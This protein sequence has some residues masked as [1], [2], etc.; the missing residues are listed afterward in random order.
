MVHIALVT[1][2]FF[3]TEHHRALAARTFESIQTSHDLEIISIINQVRAPSD[4]LWLRERC[5]VVERNDVNILAR[6]WNKGIRLGLER[7]ASHVIVSNLD[8]R[9]HPWCIDNLVEAAQRNPDTLV[10]SPF[11]WNDPYTFSRAKL[12][13]RCSRG[14]HWSCFMVDQRLF[15]AV[16]EFDEKFRPAY[17][18]DAD[19]VRRMSL[20]Q[21]SGLTCR[22]ATVLN[23]GRGTIKGMLSCEQSQLEQ[24]AQILT[25]LRADIS[26]NDERYAR[27]WGGAPGSERFAAPFDGA[28]D[29]DA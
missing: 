5:A 11:L 26:R 21:F 18:E 12:E 19:M 25:A 27:K 24:C 13:P 7:G 23:D 3:V 29:P 20:K 6:A 28:A 17:L 1:V 8:I 16:G 10:F 9:F 14:L 2:P 15:S 22:A 4:E